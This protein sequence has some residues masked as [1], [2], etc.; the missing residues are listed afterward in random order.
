M[1]GTKKPPGI[2]IISPCPETFN[3]YLQL[4]ITKFLY[5]N[6]FRDKRSSTS[7]QALWEINKLYPIHSYGIL[8]INTLS[9]ARIPYSFWGITNTYHYNDKDTSILPSTIMQ[10][11]SYS[12][13]DTLLS[14]YNVLLLL[15]LHLFAITFLNHKNAITLIADDA[16]AEYIIL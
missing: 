13:F 16:T 14:L 15:L 2:T 8:V 3:A 4:L 7:E 6:T 12:K 1:G 11:V 9:S 5:P 10:C